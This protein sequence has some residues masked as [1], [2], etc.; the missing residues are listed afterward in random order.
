V[1]KQWNFR[2][3]EPGAAQY[4]GAFFPTTLH[5]FHYRLATNVRNFY[6][7]VLTVASWLKIVIFFN[8]RQI[9]ARLLREFGA[10]IL[11][12]IER[13]LQV[14]LGALYSV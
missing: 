7:C 9:W 10:R 3:S 4:S 12:T 8:G 11:K 1:Q 13:A 5:S 14:H 2:R 6:N